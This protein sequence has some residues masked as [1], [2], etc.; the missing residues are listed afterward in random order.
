MYD[1]ELVTFLSLNLIFSSVKCGK[2]YHPIKSLVVAYPV[3]ISGPHIS[4]P[5]EL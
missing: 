2:V 5:T 3:S 4:F 1:P